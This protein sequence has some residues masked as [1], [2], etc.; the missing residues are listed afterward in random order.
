[1]NQILKKFKPEKNEIFRVM[2]N[3]GKVINKDYMPII[4]NN[5]LLDAYKKMLFERTA[6]LMT[7]SYQ[8]QGRIF[9]YPPNIGQ[10]AIHISAGQLI[11]DEDWLVPAFR[12]LG[13]MLAK[14]IT[15][16]EIFLYYMG[17]EQGSNFKDANKVLPVS[18]PIASQ[19]IHAAGIGYAVTYKNLDEIVFAYAG[20]GATSE[21]DFHEALN[22]A[23]VWKAPVIFTIQ[24]NQYAISVPFKK[25]TASKNIAIKSIAYGMKGLLVDGND[26]LAMYKSYQLAIESI[27]NGEGPIL[28][29]AI[30]YRKGAHTTSDDPTKYRTKEEENK[31]ELTDPLKRM[32]LFLDSLNLLKDFDEEKLINQYKKEIDRMFIAAEDTTYKLDDAFKWNYVDLPDDLIKQKMYYENFIK[33]KNERF[34]K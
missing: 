21:G 31:W 15:L 14:G 5:V 2:D 30:T 13:I 10:E 34:N 8:R 28:I 27:K 11:R 25:Q 7:V 32:K 1:M 18:V 12:E 20:D 16:E 23:A 33:W 3:N 6:D 4:G 17:N 26:Y 24:N 9:T 29:E 19:L 22:F